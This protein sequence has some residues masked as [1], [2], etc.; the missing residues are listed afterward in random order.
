MGFQDSG[1]GGKSQL[2]V[3]CGRR[4]TEFLAARRVFRAMPASRASSSRPVRAV[5]L[6][7]RTDWGSIV[8]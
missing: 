5:L 4:L 7:A 8:V 3:Y 1:F 6:K 2:E